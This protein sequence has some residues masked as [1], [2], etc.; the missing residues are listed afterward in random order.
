M[1]AG[2]VALFAVV[3]APTGQ[4]CAA[5]IADCAAAW[6][7]F[8]TFGTVTLTGAGPSETTSATAV[9]GATFVP[10][11]G[12]WLITDPAGDGGAV[13]AGDRADR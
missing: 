2:T 13:R 1:P 12:F 6:V 7:W 5:V 8:T 3:T 4:A 10:A 11:A 9:P